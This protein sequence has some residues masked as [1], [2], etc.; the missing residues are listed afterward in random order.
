MEGSSEVAERLMEGLEEARSAQQ[1]VVQ[2]LNEMIRVVHNYK[3]SVLRRTAE[4]LSMLERMVQW[5]GCFGGHLHFVVLPRVPCIRKLL[6]C[7]PI[8]I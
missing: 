6:G 8:N 1:V 2:A 4:G 3:L 5:E 7:K